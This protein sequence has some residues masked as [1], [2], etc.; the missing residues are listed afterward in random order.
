MYRAIYE[1]PLIVEWSQ[2]ENVV[3]GWEISPDEGGVHL[4][5][6][7]PDGVG[8]EALIEPEEVDTVL[9]PAVLPLVAGAGLAGQAGAL[10]AGDAGQVGEPLHTQSVNT[11]LYHSADLDTNLTNF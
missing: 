9:V 2:K 1:R 4:E 6:F 10:H 3:T 7:A 11:I 8:A 5:V